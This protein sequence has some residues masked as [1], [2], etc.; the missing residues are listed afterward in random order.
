MGVP[1][2]KKLTYDSVLKLPVTSANIIWLTLSASRANARANKKKGGTKKITSL[3][4]SQTSVLFC[5]HAM[6]SIKTVN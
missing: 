6:Q 3:K 5:I 2:K 1:L 4:M